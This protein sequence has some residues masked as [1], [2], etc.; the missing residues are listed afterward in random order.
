MPWQT[1]NRSADLPNDKPPADNPI[2]IEEIFS[3]FKGI[4]SGNKSAP[5]DRTLSKED[6]LETLTEAQ[7]NALQIKLEK[8]AQ[9][10]R[11]QCRIQQL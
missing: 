6:N 7:L 9:H 11:Q 10:A 1:R 5:K 2:W 4:Q 3:E 8:Q